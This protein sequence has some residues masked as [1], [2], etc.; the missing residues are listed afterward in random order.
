[1]ENKKLEKKIKEL[2]KEIDKI[3]MVIKE[4]DNYLFETL[5]KKIKKLEK[6]R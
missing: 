4:R 6:K 1:M 2:E 5:S 3:W